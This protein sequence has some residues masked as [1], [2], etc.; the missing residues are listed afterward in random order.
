[1]QAIIHAIESARRVVAVSHLKPDGDALGSALGL[2]GCLRAAGR[3]AVATT[4]SPLPDYYGF[5]EHLRLIVPVRD[6]APRDGDLLVFCDCSGPDRIP[7]EARHLAGAMPCA[8]IDHHKTN[9]GFA[10]VQYVDP[11]CG[12]ASELVW[13]VAK[14]AGWPIDAATAEALWVGIYTDTGRFTFDSTTPDTLRCA[15]ELLE[16]GVRTNLVTEKIYNET[17]LARLRLRARAIETLRL[18]AEGRVAFMHLGAADYAELGC[19][20]ADSEFFVDIPRSIRGVRAAAFL[21]AVGPDAASLSL[22]TVPP[23]DASE[24]CRLRGGGGHA[25]ASGATFRGRS[26]DELREELFGELCQWI[27]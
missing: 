25:R 12:S 27:R 7:E 11:D 21:Y 16:K 3:D 10:P 22:R 18:G 14:K 1:M 26:F 19:T 17:S 8:C 5:L 6:I 20:P 9:A 2:V 15:A 4:L 23:H 13:R 24:F